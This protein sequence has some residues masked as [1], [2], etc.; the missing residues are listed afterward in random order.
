M[1]EFKVERLIATAPERVWQVLTDAARLRQG[2]G[3]T[4]L[5]GEI[6]PGGRLKLWSEA[7][8]GRAFTLKVASM[9]AP[10][11]M[12]WTGGMPLGLFTGT[13]RFTLA[14][15][16]GGTLFVMHEVYTGPLAGLIGKSIPDLTPS[17]TTF[18]DGLEREA[19]G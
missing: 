14:A 6:V 18:A 16:G 12:V 5:E 3:I 4:R 17:F 8:P 11:E 19:T 7:S 13:R 1:L 9:A 10:R 15:R 2:F